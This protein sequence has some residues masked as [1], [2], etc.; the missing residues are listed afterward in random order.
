MKKTIIVLG[1]LIC[2]SAFAQEI[3]QPP[4]GAEFMVQLLELLASI[5]KVGPVIVMAI[6]YVG[7]VAA[8][9]TSISASFSAILKLPEL[10]ARWKGAPEFE[11]KVV[12]FVKKIKPYLDYAS[13]FNAKFK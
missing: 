6:K 1:S 11:A 12:D 3:L 5:P 7:L 2:G 4:P 8:V 10:V 9:M 13:I